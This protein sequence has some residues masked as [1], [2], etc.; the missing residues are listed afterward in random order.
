MLGADTRGVVYAIRPSY[1]SGERLAAVLDALRCP[2][3]QVCLDPAASVMTGANPL[4]Y[5]ERFVE[6]VALLHARDATAGLGDRAGHETRLGEGEVDL[7]DVLA[8]LDAAA[9]PG[10]YILRRTDSHTPVADL[11]RARATLQQLLPPG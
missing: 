1:D 7:V 5:I 10:P 4:A 2:S 6:Q 8:T 9:Y 11:Q 3:I